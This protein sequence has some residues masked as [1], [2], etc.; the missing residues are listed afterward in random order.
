MPIAKLLYKGLVLQANGQ[1]DA[2]I[3]CYQQV[4]QLQPHHA[5]AHRVLALLFQQQQRWREAAAHF[6]QV[7]R[8]G[9]GDAETFN[10]LGI[11]LDMLGRFDSA[12]ENFRRALAMRQDYAECWNNLGNVCRKTGDYEWAEESLRNAWRLNPTPETEGNLG[13]LCMARGDISGAIRYFDCALET[14][15]TEPRLLWNKAMAFFLLGDL[16]QAWAYYEYGFAAGTRAAR[17]TQLPR[18][19]GSPQ[20]DLKLLVHAEQGIGDEIMF[21]SCLP[22]LLKTTSNVVIECDARLHSLFLRSFPNVQLAPRIRGEVVLEE[23]SCRP[24]QQIAAG[25]LPR[26]YRPSFDRFPGMPYLKADS[27]E[28]GKWRQRYAALGEGL[29]I[30]VTWRGGLS[31][32]ALRRSTTIDQWTPILTMP[33]CRFINLQ[34]GDCTKERQHGESLYGIRLNDW[35]DTDHYNNLDQLA[36]QIAALDLVITVSNV[37]AHLAGALGVPTWILLP[38]VPSWRWFMNRSDCPWY[39]SVRLF[40]QPAPGQW[41]P[42]FNKIAAE[43]NALAEQV[44]PAI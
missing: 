30:G 42:V 17:C 33:D 36:A 11:C 25:S 34:Y 32:E 37:T 2:A 44:V 43:L 24:E 22:D 40:R 5:A 31:D 10:R 27:V 20:A 18:W 9:H 3:H 23:G 15:P 13:L 6:T 38:A 4:I 39:D 14:N 41:N 8:L 19:N 7:C 26:L 21:A 1:I 12:V 29:K 28:T 35:P 16:Q